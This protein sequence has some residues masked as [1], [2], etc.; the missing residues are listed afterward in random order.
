[1]D[2][3][4][5]PTH[6]PVLV[7][8]VSDLL[9]STGGSRY[10]DATVGC[11]GH[12]LV[13]LELN[14]SIQLLGIDRDPDAINIA[15][16]RLG[17]F[18]G[19]ICLRQGN[20]ALMKTFANEKGWGSVDGVLLDFGMSSLQMDDTSRGFSFQRDCA[21]DMRMNQND[22]LTAFSVLQNVSEKDLRYILRQYGEEPK[23]RR[24][25][26]AI[27]VARDK[28]PL[29][30]SS[31]LVDIIR[32]AANITRPGYSQTVARCFQALRIAVNDE[33]NS[34]KKGL[35]AAIDLLHTGGRIL[36]ISFH[37]LEDRIV[38]NKFRFEAAS[39]VCPPGLPVCRCKKKV[40]LRMLTKKPITAGKEECLR[41]SRSRPAK[42][43]A[44]EKL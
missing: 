4:F 43:R 3:E 27:T 28:G 35:D 24:I 34:I 19:R 26:S 32:K 30:R 44:A 7:K 31:E 15:R 36:T 40:R 23:A 41:N 29:T 38:K 18:A 8:E 13:L 10:I 33:L 16:K 37:S 5:P 9:S 25:A 22:E 21:L 1:M 17:N 20:F 11:G 39:C 2:P 14:K 42:L 6:T 12:A